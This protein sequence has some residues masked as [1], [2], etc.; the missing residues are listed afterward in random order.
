MISSFTISMAKLKANGKHCP[1]GMVSMLYLGIDDYIITRM[2]KHFFIVGVQRSGTTY[3]ANVLNDHPDIHVAHPIGGPLPEPKFFVYEENVQKGKSFYEETYF[4]GRS[5]KLFGEKSAAY[6]DLPSIPA[7]IH[8]FFPEATILFMLRNPVERA[9]SN[10]FLSV[11]SEK[12]ARDP[13]LAILG[14]KNK[15][16]HFDGVMCPWKYLERGH[17]VEAIERYEKLFSNVRVHITEHFLNNLEAIQSLYAHLDVDTQH[18]PSCL[19][20]VFNQAA[21]CRD[22]L[23]PVRKELREYY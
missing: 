20:T 23:E 13:W 14:S 16:E 11:R 4:A 12:E 21:R 7:R 1:H 9:I 8:S 19:K 5:E 3:L 10:Y 2:A 18:E 15:T 22:R 6:A 17:Y